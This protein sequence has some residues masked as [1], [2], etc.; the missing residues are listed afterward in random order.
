MSR[1]QTIIEETPVEKLLPL[2]LVGDVVK[3]GCFTNEYGSNVNI[4]QI[5]HPYAEGATLE[6]IH[7]PAHKTSTSRLNKPILFIHGAF[8]GAWCFGILQQYYQ[9]RGIDTYAVSLRNHGGSFRSGWLW[10]PLTHLGHLS[11]DVEVA[12]R[13]LFGQES[14]E[15]DGEQR[16]IISPY[17]LVGHS[18]GGAVVQRFL[19]LHSHPKNWYDPC[20]LMPSAVVTLFSFSPVSPQVTWI[21]NW[22]ARHPYAMLSAFFKISP[23]CVFEGPELVRDGFFTERTPED[24]ITACNNRLEKNESLAFMID[25]TC[26]PVFAAGAKAALKLGTDMRSPLRNKI[27]VF[28]AGDDKIITKEIWEGSAAIYGTS[29]IVIDGV[30]HNG[31]LDLEWQTVATR[32]EESI[33]AALTAGSSRS[34]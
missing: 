10:E 16:Q 19:S 21:Q 20:S 5:P 18:V 24:I 32:L 6:C 12:V 23:K 22:W 2:A 15:I 13:F 1:T 31:F 27:L 9:S 11:Q 29:P 26:Q 4:I 3:H 8:H 25:L 28:G 14:K 7:Y 33:I 34:E 30:G 17:I